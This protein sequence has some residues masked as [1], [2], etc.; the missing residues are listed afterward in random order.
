MHQQTRVI[1]YISPVHLTD[2]IHGTPVSAS[3]P[4]GRVAYYL[5]MTLP[6]GS[7]EYKITRGSW[8][9]GECKTGGESISNRQ[10]KLESDTTLRIMVEEWADR[11]PPKSKSSTASRQVQILD[12]AFFIP[13]LNRTHQ[14]LDLSSGKLYKGYSGTIPGV[15]HAQRTEFI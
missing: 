2:G 12:T 6:A 3:Q 10:L 11:V 14:G 13:K 5:N 1:L 9:K 4:G 8:D 7:Y 15:V